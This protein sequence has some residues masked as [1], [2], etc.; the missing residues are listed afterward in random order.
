MSNLYY[1]EHQ[2]EFEAIT[3]ALKAEMISIFGESI[4][5]NQHDLNN[6]EHYS[7]Y[8]EEM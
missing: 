7:V 3:A 5:K 8:F 1:D 2:E 6:P 4:E